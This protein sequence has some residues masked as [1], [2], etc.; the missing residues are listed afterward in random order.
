[1]KKLNLL[2]LVTILFSS[3]PLLSQEANHKWQRMAGIWEI[4]NSQA[5]E[6]QGRAVEWNYYELLNLNSILSL[7]PVNDYNLIDLTI[8]ITDRIESP[9]EVMLSF[10]IT[11]ES[12]SWYY[13]LYAFKLSGGYWGINKAAF[14]YSDRSDKSKPFNTK[15]NIFVKELASA[16]CKVKY[17]KTYTYRTAFEGENIVLY[18]NGEKI[19]SAP[20]PEKNHD[21]RIAISSRNAKIAVDKV[22]VKKGDQTLF[23]DN[24][25]KDTIY[26]KV[27]KVQKEPVTNE[28]KVEEKKP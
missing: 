17:D 4:K 18:I 8:N 20:F 27:L 3:I 6:T 24:F 15:N 19:L 23:E 25:D 26:V 22:I 14:I 21:G 2:L 7:K 16:D 1:M 10:N 12:Q 11:S 28:N 5:F 9:A 13:H